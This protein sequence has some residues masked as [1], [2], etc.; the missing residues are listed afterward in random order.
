[1]FLQL[2]NIFLFGVKLSDKSKF[3]VDIDF[4][5]YVQKIDAKKIL[6][7]ELQNWDVF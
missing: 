5:K 1:M 6:R 4:Q 2:V 3:K 7:V